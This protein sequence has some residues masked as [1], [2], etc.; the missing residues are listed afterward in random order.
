[1]N[2]TTDDGL[3]RSLVAIIKEG[4]STPVPSQRSL[5]YPVSIRMHIS[6]TSGV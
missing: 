1:M 3:S 5:H 6:S 2:V 4:N